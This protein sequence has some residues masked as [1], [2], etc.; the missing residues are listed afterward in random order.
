MALTHFKFC[1]MTTAK[2]VSYLFNS[3]VIEL[4]IT[5]I[6][7]DNSTLSLLFFIYYWYFLPTLASRKVHVIFHMMSLEKPSSLALSHLSFLRLSSQSWELYR[8]HCHHNKLPHLL[9]Q[10]LSSSLITW[11]CMRRHSC[12]E[13]HLGGLEATHGYSMRWH[14]LFPSYP[15]LNQDPDIKGRWSETMKLQVRCQLP[16]ETK[17]SPNPGKTQPVPGIRTNKVGLRE[18]WQRRGGKSSEEGGFTGHVDNMASA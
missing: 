2:K 9:I 7:V 5:E 13:K 12:S 10:L 4:I 1:N 6:Y 18:E 11:V 8:L 17:H 16:F 15:N 14:C 3:S